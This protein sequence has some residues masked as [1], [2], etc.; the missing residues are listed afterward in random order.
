MIDQVIPVTSPPRDEEDNSPGNSG[1]YPDYSI[2][3][4]DQ[5]GNNNNVIIRLLFI[6]YFTIEQMMFL[7]TLALPTPLLPLPLLLAMPVILPLPLLL[8]LPVLLLL[9]RQDE[10]LLCCARRVSN[11]VY[12]RKLYVVNP[13]LY[14]GNNYKHK[15]GE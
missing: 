4:D 1:I 15:C 11:I 12:S 8:A 5:E 6:N 9:P 2:A 7:I 10:T 3:A 14:T 13:L